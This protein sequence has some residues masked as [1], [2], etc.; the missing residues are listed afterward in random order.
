MPADLLREPMWGENINIF[1]SGQRQNSSPYAK[2]LYRYTLNLTNLPQSKQQSLHAFWNKVKGQTQPWLIQ[3]PYDLPVNG[4]I[5]VRT[6]TAPTS[7]FVVTADG[8]KV[9][10]VSGT[11]LITSAKSGPLTAGS[12]YLIDF[13]TGFITPLLLPSSADVWTAST[14]YYKKCVFSAQF[15]EQSVIWQQFS[16]QMQFTEIAL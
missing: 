9:I 7:F 13:S 14:Q 3:D 10:P 1:D 5:C 8:W 15:G 16:G 2:P 4:V 11:C 6:G 12:H